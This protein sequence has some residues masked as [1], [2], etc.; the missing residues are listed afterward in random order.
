MALSL[1]VT[2]GN[3]KGQ[4]YSV[5]DEGVMVGRDLTNGV[6]L[7]DL[8]ASR[9]HCRINVNNNS[10]QLI[11]LGSSNGTYLNGQPV[12]SSGL[13]IGDHIGI[14]Q[15]V[16]IVLAHGEVAADSIKPPLSEMQSSTL[17]PGLDQGVAKDEG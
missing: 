6:C 13:K 12:T 2:R 17:T 16:F 9:K 10:A 14:G 1:F 7:T 3:E 4:I 11:D 15:T 5:S 8:E